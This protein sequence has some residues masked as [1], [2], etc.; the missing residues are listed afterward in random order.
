[1]NPLDEIFFDQIE[2]QPT[3]GGCSQC[4]AFQTV[5]T[6]SPGVHIV[7]VHHDDWCPVLRATKSGA[8]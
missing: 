7:R 5:E 2:D 8:N 1:M 3:P 4:E 6:V